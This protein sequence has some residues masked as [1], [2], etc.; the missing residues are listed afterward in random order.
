MA[1]VA[2]SEWP[3]D[4]ERFRIDGFLVMTE[5]SGSRMFHLGKKSKAFFALGRRREDLHILYCAKSSGEV[6][7]DPLDIFCLNKGTRVFQYGDKEFSIV[8]PLYSFTLRTGDVPTLRL[9]ISALNAVIQL[10][11]L[12]EAQPLHSLKKTN[13]PKPTWCAYCKQFIWGLA[14][15][16]YSCSTCDQPFHPKCLVSLGADC[17]SPA[18]PLP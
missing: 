5:S 4:L 2:V 11:P 3:S 12:I 6:Y 10:A 17:P 13:F 15:Q 7:S 14:Y 9:W 1:A 18:P 8:H 16:G